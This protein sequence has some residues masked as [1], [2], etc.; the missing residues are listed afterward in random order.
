[1][2][3]CI[4]LLLQQ[5]PLESFLCGAA[6]SMC[7]AGKIQLKAWCFLLSFRARPGDGEVGTPLL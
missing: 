1:M 6:G 2:G 5:T 4:R 3:V 7:A